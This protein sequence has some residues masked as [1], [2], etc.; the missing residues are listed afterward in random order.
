MNE[1][2]RAIQPRQPPALPETVEALLG[3]R[4]GTPHRTLNDEVESYHVKLWPNAEY[5]RFFKAVRNSQA[6]EGGTDEDDQEAARMIRSLAQ[7]EGNA[8]VANE[9]LHTIKLA[10]H[11]VMRRYQLD[12]KTRANTL[13]GEVVPGEEE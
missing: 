11:V 6:V 10:L 8:L 3:M 4:K 12:R 5:R 1:N 9:N 7:S 13:G 2:I